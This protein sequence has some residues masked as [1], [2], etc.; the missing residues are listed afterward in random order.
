MKYTYVQVKELFEKD[1]FI[2]LNDTYQNCKETL[3]YQD[4]NGYKYC[5]TL[6]HFANRGH[7]ARIC[8]SSNPYSIDNI[9]K[10]AELNHIKSRCVENKY[11]NSKTRMAFICGCGNKFYTTKGNFFSFHKIKCDGCTG[12]NNNLTFQDVA[13]NL[14]KIGYILDLK[15]ED[16]T[17]VTTCD[18]IC[19]DVEG[20]KYKVR[21][22]AVMKGKCPDKFNK[23]N[24]FTIDNINHFLKLSNIPF[25]CISDKYI[26]SISPLEFICKRCGE[27]VIRVW[28]DVNKND[29]PNRHRILCPNCDGRN[30]SIH[31]LVL[32]QMFSHYYPDTI[33]E[34]K[35]Y[36]NPIT[37]KICPTDIV[38]HR[39]KIAIEIQSQWHDFPDQRRKDE[40][41][42]NFWLSNGYSF[43]D[44]DIRDYSV[45]EM[46]QLFFDVQELPDWINYEYSNKININTIQNMLND[47][48]PI[49]DIALKLGINIHRIYDAIYANKLKRPDGYCNGDCR[50]IVQ[51]DLNKKYVAEYIS[52]EQANSE[53]G[54]K[55]GVISGALKR[56][57]HYAKG[58]YWIDKDDYYNNNYKIIENRFSKFN[59][60]VDKFDK[61][62]NFICNYE[63]IPLAS[64]DLNVSNS[65]IL[66]VVNGERKTV[67]GFIFKRTA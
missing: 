28:R 38:N 58:Y 12:Y 33:E 25:E 29:N 50:P 22:N 27:H 1:G 5:T 39:L 2:L 42:K 24:P 56:K 45:L 13:N 8:H 43:Y 11:I 62:N 40:L 64:K 18:L 63:N 10:F 59:I 16:F 44:P 46:C 31:A 49:P 4:I 6:D 20:F 30:E 21:Y 35:T 26:D 14:E 34:D 41:K 3:L 9:N 17:G 54:Y 36:R 37:N 60:S 48:V 7:S 47:Y 51:L 65:D 15:K 61:N 55:K 67:K 53:N 23:G 57:T 66:R 32:K 52:I 19:H